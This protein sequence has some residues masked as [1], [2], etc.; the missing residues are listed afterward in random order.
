[1]SPQTM[2][3]VEPLDAG[4]PTA[5]GRENARLRACVRWSWTLGLVVLVT[6]NLVLIKWGVTLFRRVF[7][8]LM[9]GGLAKLPVL[10]QWSIGWSQSM[11]GQLLTLSAAIF[12]IVPLWRAQL[13]SKALVIS[14]STAVVLLAQLVIFSLS[15][16]LPLIPRI[17]GLNPP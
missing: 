5:L 11:F 13:G 17:V 1:M 12:G 2:P 14:A 7:D 6:L 9:P 8:D 16:C 15:L 10:T 4:A 3:P